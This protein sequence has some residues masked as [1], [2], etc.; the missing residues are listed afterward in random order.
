MLTTLF[1]RSVLV[2]NDA[3]ISVRKGFSKSELK[4]LLMKT[5]LQKYEIHRKW[6]FRWLVTVSKLS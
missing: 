1:S 6:A 4:N 5:N 2:K 3:P